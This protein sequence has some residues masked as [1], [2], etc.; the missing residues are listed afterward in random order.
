ML[1]NI[2]NVNMIATFYISTG[3]KVTTQ[4]GAVSEKTWGVW[5]TGAQLDWTK[6]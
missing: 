1:G 5:A 4:T 6:T 2:K 3:R